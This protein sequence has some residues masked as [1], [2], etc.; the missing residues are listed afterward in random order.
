MD[1]S[2]IDLMLQRQRRSLKL[3]AMFVGLLVLATAIGLGAFAL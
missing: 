2:R 1:S 3:D